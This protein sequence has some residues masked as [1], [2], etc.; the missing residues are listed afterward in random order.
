VRQGY[1]CRLRMDTDVIEDPPVLRA[2]GNEPDQAH[3]STTQWAQH[4][5]DFVNAGD[6]HCP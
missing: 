5:E 6:Q 3:L 4:R 2:L 1:V